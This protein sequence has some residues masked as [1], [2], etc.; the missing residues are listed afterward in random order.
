MAPKNYKICRL[1]DTHTHTH[2]HTDTWEERE[3]ERVG[4]C[5]KT[6]VAKCKNW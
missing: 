5:G 1:I 2:T 6:D 3:G 4:N